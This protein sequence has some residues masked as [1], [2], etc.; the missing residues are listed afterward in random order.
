MSNPANI[1]P[2]CG[3]PHNRTGQSYCQP[4]HTSY[5]RERRKIAP[6]VLTTEAR[7]RYNAR[8]YANTHEKRG[9]LHR[10]PCCV[11]GSGKTEL[12][13][14]DYDRPLYV[15]CL[16]KKHHVEWHKFERANPSAIFLEWIRPGSAPASV[17]LD[18]ATVPRGTTASYFGHPRA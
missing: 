8:S 12:H 2:K 5:V 10:T 9:Y 14:P 4:C 16:C 18:P 7:K 1:C 13:H 11:C 6:T 17:G 3:A 15:F